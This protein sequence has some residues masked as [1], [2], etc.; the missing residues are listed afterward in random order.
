[1]N[2]TGLVICTHIGSSGSPPKP[3]DDAPLTA[4]SMLMPVAS[5]TTLVTFLLSHVFVEFP[6]VK[7]ALSEGGLGWIPAAL[8][9]ADYAW[10]LRRHSRDDLHK[11]IRPSD[12]Y[13]EHVYG[14]LLDDTVGILTRHLIGVDH[15]MFESDYPHS[16]SKW[17]ASRAYAEKLL[18]DVPDDEVHRMLE[19]NARELFRFP[20][21]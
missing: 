12:M 16:D 18:V 13:R 17:P 19:F 9:R 20:R 5:W 1:V 4:T 6:N 7:L 11:D 15:I 14:C 8:E 2:E 3:S 21:R 10:E